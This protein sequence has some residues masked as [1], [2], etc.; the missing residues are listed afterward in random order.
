M[1]EIGLYSSLSPSL[2]PLPINWSG[3]QAQIQV[4]DK[5]YVIHVH[6]YKPTT[7]DLLS[8]PLPL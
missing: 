6:A 3:N 2:L 1:G 4:Q 8:L 7:Q 5:A